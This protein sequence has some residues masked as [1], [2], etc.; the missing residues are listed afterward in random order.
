M[1]LYDTVVKMSK[2]GAEVLGRNLQSA[3]HIG[4]AVHETAHGW[5]DA[6]RGF[7]NTHRWWAGHVPVLSDID[8]AATAALDIGGLVADG[9][10]VGGEILGTIG[11]R[12]T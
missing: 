4:R 12:I 8:K 2:H 1:S 7:L 5:M 6:A 3:R 9:V 10:L 11:D